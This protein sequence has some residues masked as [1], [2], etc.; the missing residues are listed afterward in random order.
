MKLQPFS[1]YCFTLLNNSCRSWKYSRGHEL[2]IVKLQ[3]QRRLATSSSVHSSECKGVIARK[4]DLKDLKNI[5][6]LSY[7]EF[8]PTWVHILLNPIFIAEQIYFN[9]RKLAFP[10]YYQHTIFGLWDTSSQPQFTFVGYVDFSLQNNNGSTDALNTR[11]FESRKREDNNSFALRP[12]VANFLVL[13]R[14]RGKGYG[15]LLV[16]TCRKEAERLGYRA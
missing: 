1:F 16:E 6:K 14:C 7:D 4:A 13:E 2:S 15:K 11:S 8:L 3:T 5:C 10:A 9:Y 12:Y